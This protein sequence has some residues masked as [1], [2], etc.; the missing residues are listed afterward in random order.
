MNFLCKECIDL[1]YS[2]SFSTCYSFFRGI[3][4]FF[5]LCL[6]FQIVFY[7]FFR[8]LCNF[9]LKVSNFQQY[10]SAYYFNLCSWDLFI[11][12]MLSI[13]HSTV[14]K[15]RFPMGRPFLIN[16]RHDHIHK[17]VIRTWTLSRIYLY[18]HPQTKFAKVMFLQACVCPRGGEYLSRY[19]LPPGQVSPL[20][21]T[22]LLPEH[23]A[24]WDTVNKWNG[25]HSC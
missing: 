17:N 12:K 5:I 19:P 15:S 14:K 22:P 20:A 1:W 3:T 13:F 25:M 2:G 6:C 11:S 23:S 7:F 10:N 18:Y 9:C 21:G 16:A 4:F 24:C 8:L